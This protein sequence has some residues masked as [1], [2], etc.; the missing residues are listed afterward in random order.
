MTKNTIFN[1][2]ELETLKNTI[3]QLSD[4]DVAF[5]LGGQQSKMDWNQTNRENLVEI[6]AHHPALAVAIE[7]ELR[8]YRGVAYNAK[9]Q[10]IKM[11]IP[12]F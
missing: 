8:F 9:G 4:D 7:P 11:R 1:D 10:R 2:Q 6:A 3:D 5:W 12:R